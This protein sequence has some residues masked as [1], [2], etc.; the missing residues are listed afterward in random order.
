MAQSTFYDILM[1]LKERLKKQDTGNRNCKLWLPN[2]ETPSLYSQ[3]H[4]L[5]YFNRARSGLGAV[6][7]LVRDTVMCEL[8]L[9]I[10]LHY[11]FTEWRSTLGRHTDRARC[12]YVCPGLYTDFIRTETSFMRARARV[13]RIIITTTTTLL[14]TRAHRT[15][16]TAAAIVYFN[17][18]ICEVWRFGTL[19]GL[20]EKTISCLIL[21]IFGVGILNRNY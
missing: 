9:F 7:A 18:A 2:V 21:N 8:L 20:T 5:K 13:H 14:R 1:E 15:P 11:S 10:S 17:K 16:A 12:G 6:T 3:R 4:L 19:N